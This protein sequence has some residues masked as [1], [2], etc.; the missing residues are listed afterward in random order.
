M[1]V[2]DVRLVEEEEAEV[3][4][5]GQVIDQLDELRTQ[6][7][8]EPFQL[9]TRTWYFTHFSPLL[10]LDH[11]HPMRVR[12]MRAQAQARTRLLR[13]FTDTLRA[14]PPEL[15][16]ALQHPDLP[17]AGLHR[18]VV[19][20]EDLNHPDDGWATF[21]IRYWVLGTTPDTSD[22]YFD[23]VTGVWREGDSATRDEGPAPTHTS[24][25]DAPDGHT[26]VLTRSVNDYL[27]MADAT[28]LFLR[29]SVAGS[30]C[31]HRLRGRT[32]RRCHPLRRDQPARRWQ[33]PARTRT[34]DLAAGEPRA[35]APA[36]VASP[37]PTPPI[38]GRSTKC[39]RCCCAKELLE[40]ARFGD[41]LAF[42]S[43]ACLSDWLQTADHDADQ[44]KMPT[45]CRPAG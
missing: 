9:L 24:W 13:H 40:P 2:G 18:G 21:N 33:C 44:R 12:T 20:S 35:A 31:R 30:R 6:G 8:P 29:D 22:R 41:R 39:K 23:L 38:R 45:T 28:P 26:L 17:H 42:G 25:A 36:A 32:G 43:M 16:L 14:L 1:P 5:R 37:R 34:T 11:G 3:G 10:P 7:T 27:S 4:A 15:S 19:L